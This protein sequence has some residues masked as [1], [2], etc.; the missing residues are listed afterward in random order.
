MG[1]RVVGVGVDGPERTGAFA[2]SCGVRYQL[3]DD[4][5]RELCRAFG[6]LDIADN[7]PH[8]TT[9][10]IDVDGVV[11]RVFAG[12]P[13]F[14]HALD[15]VDDAR[16]FWGWRLGA[17]VASSAKRQEEGFVLKVGRQGPGRQRG[18]LR[19]IDVLVRRA[20]QAHR[21]LVLPQGQHRWLNDR[22]R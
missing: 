21:A 3:A 13:P 7:R 8:P 11:R 2:A 18:F 4:A 19:R 16:E 14:G 10:M 5:S 17:A 9:F 1:V 6:V 22:S 15:V 12:I 20:R